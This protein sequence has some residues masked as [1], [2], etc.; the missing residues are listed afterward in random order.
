MLNEINSYVHFVLSG[1]TD[2]FVLYICSNFFISTEQVCFFRAHIS[3]VSTR[4]HTWFYYLLF[5]PRSVIKCTDYHTRWLDTFQII[6]NNKIQILVHIFY[7]QNR[8]KCSRCRRNLS[9]RTKLVIWLYASHF[10]TT[11]SHKKILNL[12]LFCLHL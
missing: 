2:Y 11:G 3:L 6:L 1:C 9:R 12:F 8:P 4:A 5:C 7:L 10:Y